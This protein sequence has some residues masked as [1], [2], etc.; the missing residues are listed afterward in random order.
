MSENKTESKVRKNL[1]LPQKAIDIIKA[2]KESGEF[3]SENV[4]VEKA[5]LFYDEVLKAEDGR[6]FLGD[7]IIKAMKAISQNSEGRLFSHMRSMDI[8]LT[9]LTLLF[10]YNLAYLHIYTRFITYNIAASAAKSS[11]RSASTSPLTPIYSAL[12]GTPLAA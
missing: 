9:M 2:R 3:V 5:I 12:K 10:A 6:A 1:R 4:F 7:E 11:L 8:S